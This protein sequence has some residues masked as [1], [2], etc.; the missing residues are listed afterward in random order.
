METLETGDLLLFNDN[1]TGFFG[2][3]TKLIK[4]GTHSNYSHIGMVLKN[5]SFIHPSLKG[6][7]VWESSYNGKPDPQDGKIKLGVQITPIDELIREYKK[8]GGHIYIRKLNFDKFNDIDRNIVFNNDI[9]NEIHNKVYDKPYDIVPTDWLEAFLRIDIDPQKTDRFWCSALVGYIYT[10]VGILNG[11]NDWSMM[12][13]SDF[14][15]DGE[16]LIYSGICKL[17]NKEILLL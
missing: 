4:W 1:S 3:F 13:P 5:P 16:K 12:R 14:S 17:D 8:T 10:R 2:A 7:Y 15:I 6:T 9:L 11:D